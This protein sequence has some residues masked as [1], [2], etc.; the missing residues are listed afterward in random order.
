MTISHLVLIC[1]PT[2]RDITLII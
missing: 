2:R 1:I